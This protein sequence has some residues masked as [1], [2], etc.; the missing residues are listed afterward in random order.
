MDEL[1]DF[2]FQG[3]SHE[4]LSVTSYGARWVSRIDKKSFKF[5]KELVKDAPK[6][7]MSNCYFTFGEKI[8]HQVIGIPMGSDP[9]P[10][11]A[12]LLLYY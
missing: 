6:Y 7:L 8:F 2:R 3:G 12:N 5:N 9:A 1:I 10:F 4:L 11:I